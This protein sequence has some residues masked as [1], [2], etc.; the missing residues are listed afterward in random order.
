MALLSPLAWLST[1]PDALQADISSTFADLAAPLAALRNAID[2]STPTDN[3]DISSTLDQHLSPLVKLLSTLENFPLTLKWTVAKTL[4]DEPILKQ[5]NGLRM[6]LLLERSRSPS[7]PKATACCR[8][9]QSVQQDSSATHLW[10]I[11]FDIFSGNPIA[12]PDSSSAASQPPSSTTGTKQ[13]PLRNSSDNQLPMGTTHRV[14]DLAI[15]Y[16]LNHLIYIDT[17]QFHTTYFS[18]QLIAFDACRLFLQ[19][20]GET[21]QTWPDAAMQDDIIEWFTDMTTTL[22]DKNGADRNYYTSAAHPVSG[23]NSVRKTDVCLYP[24]TKGRR[25]PKGNTGKEW[26]FDVSEVLV[27]GELKRAQ[28]GD[29]KRDIIVQLAG[30]VRSVFYAQQRRRFVHAFTLTKDWMRCFIFH[31]GG[32]FASRK[33]NVNAEPRR[34]IEVVI[35]YG[36]MTLAQLGFDTS[37]VFDKFTFRAQG[38]EGVFSI[39]KNA[40]FNREAIAGCGTTCWEVTEKGDKLAKYVLKD[41]W[42]NTLYTSEATLFKKAIDANV[43]GLVE[44]LAFPELIFNGKPDDICGCIMNGLSV[45]GRPLQL[46]TPTATTQD[47][48][49][50]NCTSPTISAPDPSLTI[51]LNSSMSLPSTRTR[52][53]HAYSL[54][55][56]TKR[57]MT[58]NLAASRP[59]RVRGLPTLSP[60][61]VFNRIHTRILMH[62]GRALYKFTSSRELLLGLHDAIEGHRSLYQTAGILHRDISIHNIMLASPDNPRADGRCGFLIDLDMAIEIG[63]PSGAPPSGAQ[64]RTGTMEFMAIEV[65]RGAENHTYRHDLESFWYVLVWIAVYKHWHQGDRVTP[66]SKWAT[67]E[68]ETAAN[69]KRFNVVRGD[70]QGYQTIEREFHPDCVGL[71]RVVDLWRKFLFPLVGDGE[72]NVKL[73]AWDDA[74]M[75]YDMILGMLVDAADEAL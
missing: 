17:P 74:D 34:F 41:T 11:I 6:W 46:I 22:L 25:Y 58:T 47:I 31:R 42:R 45:T 32:A 59:K 4:G 61:H 36:T 49:V 63:A 44:V 37:L 3:N 5:I 57:K 19:D 18:P 48:D 40:F 70:V 20:G 55:S 38:C 75:A 72:A 12:P 54:S 73:D 35:G 26:T 9:I 24:T 13:T 71:R 2:S 33:F 51:P 67:E 8:I 27:V 15:K 10:H 14:V 43:Q 56:S 69:L 23:T 52:S 50:I 68:I 60:P 64:H 16:E 29:A 7:S 39:K 65:L 66:L 62:K 28:G 21:W 53:G 30:Y 1:L